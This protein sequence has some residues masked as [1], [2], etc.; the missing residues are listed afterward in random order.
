M[1]HLR[2]KMEYASRWGKL[3]ASAKAAF[4]T[5]MNPPSM[6]VELDFGETKLVAKTTGIGV[7]NN[8]FGEGTLPYARDPAGG[9][10]GIYITIA[11]QR[12]EILRF[13]AKMARGRWRDNEQVEI[14]EAEEVTL[15][16]LSRRYRHRCV[17]D[18]ELQELERETVLKIHPRSLNVLVPSDTAEETR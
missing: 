13:I 4:S 2:S 15:R 12:G 17:I 11:R 7:T 6:R 3:R 18:G 9:L 5:V 1:V 16:I 14:H 10:L 8:L